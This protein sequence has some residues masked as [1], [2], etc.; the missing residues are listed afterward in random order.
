M[1]AASDASGASG[2]GP[3]GPPRAP[4][5][6]NRKAG[7]SGSTASGSGGRS[8]AGAAAAASPPRAPP[9]PPAPRPA[10]PAPPRP[11][12]PAAA[13]VPAPPRAPPRPWGAAEVSVQAAT[14]SSRR[15]SGD[16]SVKLILMDSP[17]P[18]TFS[19]VA[20]KRMPDWARTLTTARKVKAR[21]CRDRM[22]MGRMEPT[23]FLPCY[24][25]RR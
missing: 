13:P 8:P 15:V 24:P 6:P 4:P 17:A 3:V 18:L 25:A 19:E 7:L 14:N 16:H 20:V 9:R 11:A 10:A 1:A 22:A 21:N 2:V 23:S 5:R 12:A